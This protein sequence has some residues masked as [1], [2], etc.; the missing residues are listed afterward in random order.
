MSKGRD[1]RK[2]SAGRNQTQ[3]NDPEFRGLLDHLGRLL[4]QEY[5]ALLTTVKTPETMNPQGTDS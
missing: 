5:V 4:A 1:V 3:V 2:P